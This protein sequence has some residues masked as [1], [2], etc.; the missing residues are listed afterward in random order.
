MLDT[1]SALYVTRKEWGARPLL[2]PVATGDIWPNRLGVVIHWDGPKMGDYA[3]DKCAGLV[4]GVQ[5]YHT[6][7]NKWLDIAYTFVVCRHGYVFEGRGLRRRTAA[8]GTERSND[9]AYAVCALTGKGDELTPELLRGLRLAV[10][11]LWANGARRRVTGHRDWF[12]TDC[13]GDGLYGWLK[14]GMPL[15]KPPKPP[16]PPVPPAA[17]QDAA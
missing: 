11:Y 8:N 9:G 3:H 2:S 1:K 14:R 13:P 5:K 17:V 10:E 6:T 12:A 7:H 15:P 4:R 16:K